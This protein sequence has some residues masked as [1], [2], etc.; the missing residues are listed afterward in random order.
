MASRFCG[1]VLKLDSAQRIA[2]GERATFC[3][4][5]FKTSDQPGARN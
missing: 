4:S 5:E 2:K 3:K 1:R